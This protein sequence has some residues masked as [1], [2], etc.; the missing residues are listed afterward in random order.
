MFMETA[1]R[2]AGE[3]DQRKASLH[4]PEARVDLFPARTEENFVGIHTLCTRRNHSPLPPS[5]QC[6]AT[7]GSGLSSSYLS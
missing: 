4:L 3:C 1:L 5:A 2:F 7:T 6:K